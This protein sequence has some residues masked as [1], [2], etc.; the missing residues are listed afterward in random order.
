MEKFGR[1]RAPKLDVQ[2]GVQTEFSTDCG[3]P[4][5]RPNRVFHKGKTY[6]DRESENGWSSRIK[7]RKKT[8]RLNL[9]VLGNI[10]VWCRAHGVL[11]QDLTDQLFALFLQAKANAAQGLRFDLIDLIDRMIDDQRAPARDPVE[12]SPPTESEKVDLEAA[13]AHEIL[14]LYSQLSGNQIR[15]GDREAMR[16]V[17]DLPDVVIYAGILRA[18]LGCADKVGSF[19]YCVK[20][21]RQVAE[22]DN[23]ESEFARL[24][25]KLLL[26]TNG[27]QLVLPMNTDKLFFGNFQ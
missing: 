26:Q 15:P 14:E 12:N 3:R 24:R 8:L 23:V 22:L 9:Q 7:R 10:E 16:E 19:S 25:E 17:F 6:A 2:L 13:R 4:I 21:M 1:P 11:V 18:V 20:V 27:G 5:G